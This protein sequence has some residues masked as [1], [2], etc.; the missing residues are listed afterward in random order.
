MRRGT[1]GLWLWAGVGEEPRRELSLSYSRAAGRQRSL[2]GKPAPLSEHLAVL[3]L[4]VWTEADRDV[5]A[6]PPAVRRRFLDRGLVHLRPALIESYGRYGAALREKRALLTAG[7]GQGG[8]RQLAAW[9]DL[10][11][12]HGA[13]IQ[14]ARVRLL[15]E[16][17][18][19]LR[20]LVERAR[21]DLPPLALRYRASAP[22]GDDAVALGKALERARA[23]ERARRA[24][25]VGPHRDEVELLWDGAAARHT[26]SAG[27]RRAVGLLLLA[28]LG[29]RLAA[30]GREPTLLLDDADAELDAARLAGL[31]RAFAEFPGLL[32]ST[33]R[34]E[35]WPAAAGLERVAVEGLGERSGGTP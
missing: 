33:N 32:V 5:V 2:D 19:E 21:L 16:L 29:R 23:E 35:L 24:P 20:G 13:E 26:A 31:L 34:P 1:D 11:A 18:E 7:A 28:A 17:E 12:R 15:G 6:G 8:E 22:E 30:G 9:N 10:L 27:E 14:A 3:P 25:L 4:L